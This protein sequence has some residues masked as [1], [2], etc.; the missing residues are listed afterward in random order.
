M[1]DLL[2]H[3]AKE[4]GCLCLSDLHNIY[5]SFVLTEAVQGLNPDRFSLSVWLDALHYLTGDHPSE[6]ER[7]ID[8]SRQAK[9]FLLRCMQETKA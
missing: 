5:P 8:N 9:E 3:L 1:D 2:D 7:K 4:T 6:S